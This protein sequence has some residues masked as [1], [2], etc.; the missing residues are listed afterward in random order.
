[1]FSPGD[2]VLSLLPFFHIAGVFIVRLGLKVEITGSACFGSF[3]GWYS[4]RLVDIVDLNGVL[5]DRRLSIAD[6]ACRHSEI[7]PS[8][9][10]R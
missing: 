4:L 1:M 6:R 9:D 7:Q 3:T 8:W 5:N 2:V 10:A